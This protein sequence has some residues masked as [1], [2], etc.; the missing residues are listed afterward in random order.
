MLL[1]ILSQD[2][3]AS[4]GQDTRQVLLDGA[5][6]DSITVTDIMPDYYCSPAG[7]LPACMHSFPH[8]AIVKTHIC[9]ALRTWHTSG[10]H[11]TDVSFGTMR[12]AP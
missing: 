5:L 6:E 2:L 1:I 4:F 9:G 3:G 8:P 10:G 12:C 11:F 7:A